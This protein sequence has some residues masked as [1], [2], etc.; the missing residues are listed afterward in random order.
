[1]TSWSEYLSLISTCHFLSTCHFISTCHY[2]STCQSYKCWMNEGVMKIFL[3]DHPLSKWI[4]IIKISSTC[5]QLVTFTILSTFHQLVINLSPGLSYGWIDKLEKIISVTNCYSYLYVIEIMW[6]V[7]KVTSWSIRD[8][9]LV[10]F[11]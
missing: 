2:L 1:M 5:H 9:K 6:Q 7:D 3:T 10:N 4:K 8:E 11:T